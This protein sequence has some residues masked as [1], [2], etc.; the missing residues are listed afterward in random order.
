MSIFLFPYFCEVN[1]FVIKRIITLNSKGEPW[2]KNVVRYV[3]TNEKYIGNYIVGF[4][5]WGSS[6]LFIRTGNRK[7]VDR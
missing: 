4:L 6:C 2:N 5:F 3:L 7:T 1:S